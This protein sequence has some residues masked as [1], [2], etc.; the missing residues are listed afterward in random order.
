MEMPK[1]FYDMVCSDI[2]RI[3]ESNQLSSEEKFKL[4]RELDGRYQACIKD[5]YKGLWG[6]DKAA[7]I[8]YYN[9]LHGS[10]SS[11]QE[12]LEMMKAKLQTFKYQMNA[13]SLPKP[14]ETNIT[15]NN[16]VIISLSFE[17]AKQ[18]IEDMTALNREQTDE[19][20]S[21]IDELEKISKEN[22]SRK[23]KWEKVKPIISFAL[24]KG[25][26][27]AIAILSLVMQMKL[28][29]TTI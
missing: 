7:T 2:K 29:G 9:S 25:A 18:K 1:G 22:I 8:I 14:A 19:I 5:W 21:K 24:D 27:V 23:S 3:E 20:L 4:H 6:S 12:N 26:D 13:L 16:T 17:E 11:V 28:G 10:P 15:V